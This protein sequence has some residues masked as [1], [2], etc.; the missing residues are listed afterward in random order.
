MMKPRSLNIFKAYQLTTHKNL[1]YYTGE[2]D[3]IL[4]FCSLKFKI[5]ED[6][7]ALERMQVRRVTRSEVICLREVLGQLRSY[8]DRIKR[9]EE[10]ADEAGMHDDLLEAICTE[11]IVTNNT[12]ESD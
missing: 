11:D 10:E 9:L 12:R 5:E 6:D 3:T 2:E 7:I 4:S 1:G 8:T